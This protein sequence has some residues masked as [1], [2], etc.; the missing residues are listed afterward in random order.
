MVNRCCLCNFSFTAMKLMTYI[1]IPVNIEVDENPGIAAS[2][3]VVVEAV[4]LAEV[5]AM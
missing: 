2:S 1:A 3:P 5:V 4:E